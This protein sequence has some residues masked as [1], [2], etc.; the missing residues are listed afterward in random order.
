MKFK[1]KE[2]TVRVFRKDVTL[3]PMWLFSL[4]VAHFFGMGSKYAEKEQS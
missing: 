4:L 1:G 2:Y 3:H